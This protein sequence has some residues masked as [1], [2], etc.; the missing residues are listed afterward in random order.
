MEEH[1]QWDPEAWSSVEGR[2]APRAARTGPSLSSVLNELPSAATLRYRGPG[3][4][5]WGSE[6]TEDEE[7]WRSM[8]TSADAAH[9]E[10][11]EPGA[12]R[13]LPWPMPARRAHRQ[14]LARDRVAQGAGSTGAQWT[15]LIRRSKEKVREGLRSLQPWA[16]TLKRIGGQFG[17]GTESYFSLLR[18]LLLLNVLASVLTACM[19]LL[20]TWLEGTPPGP[21]APNASSPCGS[22]NPGSH[23]LVTFSTELFNLL[24]GEGFLEW[25]P[26]FYGFYPPRSHLAITYL[27]AAFAIGLLYLLLI[28]HRSVS[29]LKQTLLAESE[30]LTRYSHRVFSAWD[31][32]LS[33][34][35]HVRLRQRLILYDL[36]VELEE[37]RV[38][39]KAAVR[40]LGQQARLWSVRLLLNLVVL[41]LLGAAFYG[42]YWATG[43]TVDLQDKPLIQ[44]T[45]VLK[46]VVDYLP[47]IF[48]SMVNFVLPPVFKL[49]APL[50]GYTRS[51]QIVFILLRTVSLRLVSLLVLLFSLWNEIT[52]GAV[53]EECKTCGYNYKALP[54]WETRMGQE[55][56]KLL[57]FDL[58]TGLAVILLYQFPRKLLCGLCPGALG[59]FARTQEFQVPDEV[60][61]LIYA[62]TVVWVGSFFCPLLPLLNTVKFLLLFYLKK[63]PTFQA[64]WSIPGSVVHLGGDPHV[65][66]RTAS[67]GPECSLLSGYPGFCCAPSADLQHPDGV[68]RGPG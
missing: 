32:G 2:P 56:Y 45:P 23:G 12:S 22:Y 17:A 41:A 4:L 34:E 61:G 37:A 24:S 62:Q 11:P 25:S 65:Y 53:P 7:A 28:L 64:V 13:E 33:G 52:C 10:Q 63:D 43:A 30:A 21:P 5:P 66:P 39:R 31:F 46:L 26:L 48:I 35:V 60:L 20:P 3:V 68:Y 27:C 42:I 16:W 29:G 55:M 58:L 38:R 67:D 1:P 44:R 15:R 14:R 40:T 57:L 9:Q 18:F 6:E 36:Q 19:V 54:C 49:I 50:E 47:S 8:Q 59:R 51:R